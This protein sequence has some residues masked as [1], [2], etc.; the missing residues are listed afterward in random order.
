[1][2][3]LLGESRRL[4]TDPRCPSCAAILNGVTPAGMYGPLRKLP[5]PGDFTVCCYCAAILRFAPDLA[6]EN[7]SAEEMAR[8]E[9]EERELLD[10][11]VRVAK[12]MSGT[13]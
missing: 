11:M 13:V 6:L 4:A 7:V 9:P 12:S 5:N 2:K 10:V 1:L 8:F 3:I